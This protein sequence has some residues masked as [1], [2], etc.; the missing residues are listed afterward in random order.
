MAY[1]V[2][3]DIGGTFTDCVAVDETGRV[4][5]A[6]TPST[7]DSSPVAGVLT[8]LDL[9]AEAAELSAGELYADADRLSHGT[10]IGTNLIVERKGARVALL[11]TAGHGDAL[12]MMRGNGR[13]AGI[14]AD[15][16][17]RVHA[18]DK[19][20]PL[21]D[22][23]RVLEVQERVAADGEVLAPLDEAAARERLRE[24]LADQD[25]EA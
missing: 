6:K 14:P 19:P 12:T 25:V 11:A 4:F 10:T 20:A 3:V 2:G 9:L 21:V 5:H 1:Y 15:Q 23:A 18:T 24:L 8:G 7:H 22:Q 17:F 13:T 16:V